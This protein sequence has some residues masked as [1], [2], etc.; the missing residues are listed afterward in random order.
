MLDVSLATVSKAKEH[1][2]VIVKLISALYRLYE[3]K[4]I[5]CEPLTEVMIDEAH[6]SHVT[7]LLLFD[8]E[9][10]KNVVIIEVTV[11]AAENKDFKQVSA[12]VDKY[13]IAEGFVYNYITKQWRKYKMGIGEIT[14]N[15]SFCDSIGYDLNDFL[16]K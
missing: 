1:Q 13:D 5:S 15:P 2:R 10:E 8:P 6:T 11:T 16:S 3:D 4:L 14:E 7:E 9:A 12:L